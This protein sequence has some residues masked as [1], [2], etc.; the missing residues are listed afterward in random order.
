MDFQKGIRFQVLMSTESSTND[1]HE[2]HSLE[3]L[4]LSSLK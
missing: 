2:V 1:E 4:K 3:L